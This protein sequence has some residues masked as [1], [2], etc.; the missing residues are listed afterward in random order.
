MAQISEW[1]PKTKLGLMVKKGEIVSIHE[2]F[3]QSLKIS[4]E[5]IIDALVQN[6]EDEVININ[7]VQRQTDAGEKSRFKACVAVGNRN[8]LVGIGEAKTKEIGPAI[9]KAITIAKL[10]L[11]PIRRGCGSWE[12]SCHDPHSIPFKVRGKTGN[13][14]VVAKPAPKGLGLA[15]GNIAKIVFELAGITDI[16]TKTFGETRTTPNYAKAAF[17]ALK[18]SYK[19]VT[20]KDWGK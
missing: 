7:L 1:Q 9:R 2:I 16:W 18:G 20:P 3:K 19:V 6:L 17:E 13:C 4:E 15:S 10:H 14:V 12:C 8:G 5:E 11:S